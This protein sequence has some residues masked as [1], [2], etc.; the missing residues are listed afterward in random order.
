[1]SYYAK[2]SPAVEAHTRAFAQ[3]K[4]EKERH[5]DETI[6]RYLE[7]AR[8]ADLEELAEVSAAVDRLHE[9]HAEAIAAKA[10]EDAEAF[11]RRHPRY[12]G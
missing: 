2:S 7:A 1:M 9:R 3:A 5:M 12:R 8:H 4:S 10:A 11:R 6:L